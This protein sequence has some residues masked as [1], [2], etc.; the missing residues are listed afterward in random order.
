M[1]IEQAI[2]TGKVRPRRASAVRAK[3]SILEQLELFGPSASRK[4][5]AA[6]ERKVQIVDRLPRRMRIKLGR[7]ENAIA[8]KEVSG[9]WRWYIPVPNSNSAE[10]AESNTLAI[11]RERRK[12]LASATLARLI[13]ISRFTVRRDI[14]AGKFPEGAV[15]KT[16]NHYYITPA[17]ALAYYEATI[18]DH[19][20]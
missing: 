20:E 2:E 17:A 18:F 13:G 10:I 3:S 16:R 19:R 12:P 14:L 7:F 5:A 1:T 11:L 4:A 15:M 6:R 8:I 9:E